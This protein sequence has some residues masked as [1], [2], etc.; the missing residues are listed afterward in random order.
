MNIRLI[1]GLPYVTATL[2]F[3][4]SQLTL[5]KVVLDTGSAGTVLPADKVSAIGLVAEPTDAVRQIFG[6]GGAES[7]FS[8]QVN[9]LAVG[10]LDVADFDIQIGA[11]DYNIDIDGIIGFDF[12][13]R[14]GAL[15]DL[16]RLEIRNA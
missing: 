6:I 13:A 15:I 14:V 3:R 16:L 2:T 5:D 4:G 9:H 10:E 8:K 7:V 1:D 12:L 11:L